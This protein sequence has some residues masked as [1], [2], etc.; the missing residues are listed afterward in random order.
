VLTR[1]RA[2]KRSTSTISI[3]PMTLRLLRKKRR[4]IFLSISMLTAIL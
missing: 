3:T 4:Q 1:P 2:N